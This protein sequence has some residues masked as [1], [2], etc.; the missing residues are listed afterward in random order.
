MATAACN[1][2]LNVY[3][4]VQQN[5]ETHLQVSNNVRL[6]KL[7]QNYIFLGEQCLQGWHV[8]KTQQSKVVLMRRFCVIIY[9]YV[10]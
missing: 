2:L 10:Y 8:D 3:L 9:F 7:C 5:K 6:S 1:I 4:C